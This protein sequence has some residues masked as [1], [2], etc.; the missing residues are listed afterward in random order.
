VFGDRLKIVAD[1]LYSEQAVGE[2]VALAIV[3]ESPVE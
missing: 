1:V 2:H 3:T